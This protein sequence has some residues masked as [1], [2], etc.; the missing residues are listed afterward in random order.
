MLKNIFISVLIFWPFSILANGYTEQDKFIKFLAVSPS[1]EYISFSSASYNIDGHYFDVYLNILDT[2][3]GD[4]KTKKLFSK[5]DG[6]QAQG[7]LVWGYWANDKEFYA[8]GGHS[9]ET[10]YQMI[11]SSGDYVEEIDESKTTC[12]GAVESANN[13][14]YDIAPR[15]YNLLYSY[16]SSEGIG[17][18]YIFD[19]N[20]NNIILKA[21]GVGIGSLDASCPP[22]RF[23]SHDLNIIDYSESGD[24]FT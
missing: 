2:S 13:E 4:I 5:I 11:F 21:T 6:H 12:H 7:K 18:F 23:L 24:K 15:K 1:G 14:F 19:L 8:G 20:N 17:I 9:Y 3:V 22:S 16:A 10:C